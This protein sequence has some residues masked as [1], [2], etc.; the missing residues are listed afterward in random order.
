MQIL[1]AY[2]HFKVLV[3]KTP[4]H[5]LH[6]HTRYSAVRLNT[7]VQLNFIENV[8]F[9][10]TI[11]FF[12][13]TFTSI[14]EETYYAHIMSFLMYTQVSILGEYI[15]FIAILYFITTYRYKRISCCIIEIE[16][17]VGFEKTSYL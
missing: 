5:P 7:Y 4:L 11:S 17:K 1:P 12:C 9:R 8:L 10:K 13:K 2:A 6:I 16:Y 3:V 15:S 14:M